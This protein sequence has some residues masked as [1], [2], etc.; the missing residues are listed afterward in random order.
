MLAVFQLFL[1][2]NAKIAN[3]HFTSLIGK[4]KQTV[5]SK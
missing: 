2:T 4:Q 1:L 5:P 3:F